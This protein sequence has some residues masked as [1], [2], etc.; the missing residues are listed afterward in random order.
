LGWFITPVLIVGVS[1]HALAISSQLNRAGTGIKIV[2]FVD[3][4]LPVGSQVMDGLIVLGTTLQIHELAM[5][6][7]IEQ[8]ILLP[9]AVSWETFQEVMGEAGFSNGYELQL[10]P[11]FFEI[12]TTNVHLTYKA[13]IPLLS[14]DQVHIKGLD[15]VLKTALDFGLGIV[16]FICSL[17]LDI[18]I[19]L[20]IWINNDRPVLIRHKVFGL[21]GKYFWT[22][23]FRTELRRRTERG[24]E[25]VSN[26][27]ILDS[28]DFASRFLNFLYRTGLD[29]LPQLM[30]VVRG[31]LSLVGPR[32]TSAGQDLSSR[33]R[34]PSLLT[35]K[36]GWIGPWAVG[37]M[38]NQDE[39]ITQS[40][41]Y[42]R[43]WTIWLDLQILYQALRLVLKRR[44]RKSQDGT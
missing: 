32:T 9:N 12:L 17:P 23:K 14:V 36:P 15:L 31:H 5:A 29:K 11:G 42:I 43:N 22:T 41:Y 13:F 18:L 44:S 2:G 3:E 7:H 20:A 35:V 38:A 1:D 27:K 19:G 4:F 6:Y 33:S 25:R 8:V 16:L 40:L 37:S 39:E 30:D 26:E 21:E 10:S 24:F 28:K 34:H